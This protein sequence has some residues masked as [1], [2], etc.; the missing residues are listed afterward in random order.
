MVAILTKVQVRSEQEL[1][2]ME[3]Q[4]K[5]QQAMQFEHAEANSA[6]NPKT[7]QQAAEKAQPFRREGRKIGRNEPCFCGSGKK[8]KHCHGKLG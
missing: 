2:A 4:N 8:F 5:K 7:E 1:Q 3:E 6:L